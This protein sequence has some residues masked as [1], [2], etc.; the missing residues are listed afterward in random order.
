MQKWIDQGAPNNFW[1]S[2]F[3][4]T[5]SFLTGVLQNYARKYKIP[6]DTLSFDYFV[7]P[8]DSKKH[9]V[10]KAPADGCFIHGLYFDGA[11]WD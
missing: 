3:F 1:I 9:D 10:T 4:F 7:I 8:K 2:G 5:Q 11:R 6:I